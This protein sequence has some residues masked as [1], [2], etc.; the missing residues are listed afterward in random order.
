MVAMLVAIAKSAKAHPHA[1]SP[2]RGLRA[3]RLSMLA[4]GWLRLRGRLLPPFLALQR[5]L[6]RR[7]SIDNF[8]R[9]PFSV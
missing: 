5:V 4:T 2:F 8:C 6:N 3:R 7:F 1:V 9:L